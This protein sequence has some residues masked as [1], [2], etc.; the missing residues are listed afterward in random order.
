M[1]ENG[2]Y[3][4]LGFLNQH[5]LKAEGVK[6]GTKTPFASIRRIVQDERFFFKIRPGL[7]ALKSFENKLPADITPKKD[8]SEEKYYEYSH[9]FY[10]GLL[11]EI[12]NLNGYQTYIPNQDKNKIF[13]GKKISEVATISEIYKFSYPNIVDISKNIDVIWFNRRN[14]PSKLFEIEHTTVI[15]NSLLK[16]VEL[17]DFYTRYY[18]VADDIRRKEFKLKLSLQAFSPIFKRV[19]FWSYDDVAE[20][21]T[22]ISEYLTIKCKIGN[23]K[24]L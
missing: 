10:Q 15:Y 13:L 21:H 16:F 19:G 6:W 1:E 18:I 3:A 4:T 17:Q 5:V 23:M 7:W 8:Q 11:V 2:G 9:T 20:L 22:K 12:G 24:Q 14:M